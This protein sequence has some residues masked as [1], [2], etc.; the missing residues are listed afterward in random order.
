MAAPLDPLHLDDAIRRYLA[1]E[2]T[3][4]I[5]ATTGVSFKVLNRERI[6]RGIPPR[7]KVAAPWDEIIAA[8]RSG[9]S[10]YALS[11]RFDVSRSSIR[12]RLRRAGIE[13]RDSSTAGLVRAAKMRPAE[14][15]AQAA[16]AQDAARKRT[17]S[18]SELRAYAKTRERNGRL[19]SDGERH[20]V[21]LLE[22]RGLYPIPQKAIGRYNVDLAVEPVA[23]EVLGG[24]WHARKRIHATRT[25]YILDEG[26]H[27]I[28]VWS[29]EPYSPVTASAAD[30]IVALLD[31]M[32]WN[33]PAES[34]YRVISGHG[35][36][37]AA[38]RSDDGEFALVP[39]PRGRLRRGA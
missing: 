5:H 2:P 20:L 36:L 7:P 10:E 28:F 21:H 22:E 23:V 24:N 27:L 6:R 34:Q 16:P 33:P 3:K 35:Q 19:G 15:A 13:I 26:W 11:R 32:R 39:P 1:R 8:Y 37:L 17:R 29:Q 38:G 9:E 14:R 30:Y 4:Q 12:P 25:P 18:E 31:E